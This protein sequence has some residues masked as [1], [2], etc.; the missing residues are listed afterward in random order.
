MKNNLLLAIVTACI[1]SGVAQAGDL[2]IVLQGQVSS[3]QGAGLIHGPFAGSMT[4]DCVRLSIDLTLQGPPNSDSNFYVVD[5][6]EM[7][8]T[9]AG[10]ESNS[11]LVD[12]V[13]SL[14]SNDAS[15]PS[16]PTVDYILVSSTCRLESG[17]KS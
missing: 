14:S 4:G 15:F 11:K 8:L 9:I 7:A 1:A 12:S 13:S 16:A 17:L 3:L 2:Q 5:H 10:V 6:E